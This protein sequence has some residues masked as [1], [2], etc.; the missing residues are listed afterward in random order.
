MTL[1]GLKSEVQQPL[2]WTQ[3]RNTGRWGNLGSED[4]VIGLRPF[5]WETL[6]PAKQTDSLVTRLGLLQCTC[7]HK[8]NTEAVGEPGPSSA[9][10]PEASALH[11]LPSYQEPGMDWKEAEPDTG[12]QYWVDFVCGS[13]PSRAWELTERQ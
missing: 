11:S 8:D 1:T 7:R 3:Q 5:C 4:K 13:L 6:L 12:L 10:M 2:L 9:C